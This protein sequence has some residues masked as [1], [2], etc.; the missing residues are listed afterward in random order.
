MPPDAPRC[1][2]VD[3]LGAN[4]ENA[5]AAG[6]VVPLTGLEMPDWGVGIR[7]MPRIRL[8]SQS[9]VAGRRSEKLAWRRGWRGTDGTRHP[10]LPE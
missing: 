1:P 6:A 4:R 10:A 7:A 3:F 2:Q 8:G 9:E 5:R